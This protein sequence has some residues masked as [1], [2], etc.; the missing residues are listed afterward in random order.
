[1]GL[2]ALMAWGL[3]RRSVLQGGARR[4]QALE[5]GGLAHAPFLLGERLRRL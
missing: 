4:D 3:T 5:Q 1:M 2:A